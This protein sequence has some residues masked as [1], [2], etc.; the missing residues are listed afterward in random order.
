MRRKLRVTLRT[1][2][3]KSELP[4]TAALAGMVDETD[5]MDFLIWP[6]D[7]RAEEMAKEAVEELEAK[8]V[9]LTR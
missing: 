1:S 5:D 6:G 4:K 8:F 7:K 9:K 2:A 3:L